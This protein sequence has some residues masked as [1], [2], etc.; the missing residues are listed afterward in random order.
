MLC[1]TRAPRLKPWGWYTRGVFILLTVPGPPA[2]PT[3]CWRPMRQNGGSEVGPLHGNRPSGGFRRSHGLRAIR[4]PETI[5]MQITFSCQL[6]SRLIVIQLNKSTVIVAKPSRPEA[7]SHFSKVQLP[8][9]YLKEVSQQNLEL[10]FN[11]IFC[12]N[13]LQAH[14]LQ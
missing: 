6:I 8:A 13:Q 9:W 11:C 7:G 1:N 5:V 10:L 3:P 2:G 14:K 12:K 4:L